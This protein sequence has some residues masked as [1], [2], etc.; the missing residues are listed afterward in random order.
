MPKGEVMAQAKAFAEDLV[1]FDTATAMRLA[2]SA[3]QRAGMRETRRASDVG[4]AG[5]GDARLSA[6]V[7][8]QKALMGLS[9]GIDSALVAAIAVEALGAENVQGMGMP[10]EFSSRGR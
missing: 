10:S 2:S 7:R 6:E 9:G 5:A 1:V 3:V 8:V 4:C